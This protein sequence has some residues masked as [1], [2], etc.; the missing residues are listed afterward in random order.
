MIIFAISI[1]IIII[2]IIIFIFLYVYYQNQQVVPLT[3]S[4]QTTNN[5]SND[6]TSSYIISGNYTYKVPELLLTNCNTMSIINNDYIEVINDVGLLFK[7]GGTYNFQINFNC[8]YMTY[9]QAFTC[10]IMFSSLS[11]DIKSYFYDKVG[12]NVNGPTFLTITTSN[13]ALNNQTLGTYLAYE[14]ANQNYSYTPYSPPLVVAQY[15]NKSNGNIC[16]A[17][18]HFFGG[19]IV[20][21]DGIE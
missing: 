9:N 10:Y 18:Y 19:T 16:Y 7:K 5:I 4:N 20:V 14:Q 2:I 12:G 6:G 3:T 13:F 1:I 11:S 17:N 15:G 21:E 8:T